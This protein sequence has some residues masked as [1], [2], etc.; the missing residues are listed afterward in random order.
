MSA[1]AGPNR[2]KAIAR[3]RDPEC[4]GTLVRDSVLVIGTSLAAR[5]AFI[6]FKGPDS[7]SFDLNAWREAAGVLAAGRNPYLLTPFFSWPPVWIQI[8]F[9]LQ[10]IGHLLGVPL[11]WMIPIFLIAMESVLIVVLLAFLRELGFGRRRELTILGIALNPV[12]IILV[13][14][15]GNFDVLVGLLVLLG[16]GR[17][18]RF[19][20]SHLGEDWLLACCWLG[21]GIALKS[22]PVLL[23]PLLASGSR[24]LNAR[25]LFLGSVLS[26]GP[27]LYGLSI[28]QVFRA[29]NVRT[30]ILGYRSVSGWFGVTGWFHRMG[31]DSWIAGYSALFTSLILTLCV[32]LT[33]AAYR[34]RI[35][36]PVR[37]VATACVQ[38]V[39]VIALGPGY[40][41][42]YFYWFWPILLLAFALGSPP[43]RRLVVAFGIVAGAT[44]MVEYAFSPALGAFLAMRFPSTKNLVFGEG[45]EVARVFTLLSTPLW[46]AYLGLSAALAVECRRAEAALDRVA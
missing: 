23:L 41:P 14:Q 39:L 2:Q 25:T 13:C 6:W 5:A 8:L 22:I 18:I 11:I 28:L 9:V 24:R 27:T 37:L 40:G 34:D 36:T 46:L 12:C 16:V 21:L 29:A 32:V 4:S 10:R 20:Q 30:Q 33:V 43:F 26:L 7:I 3:H 31:R 35:A 19:E 38:L 15:H 1:A 42:Q 45:P 44:Y 17:L